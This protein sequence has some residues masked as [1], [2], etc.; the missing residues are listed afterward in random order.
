VVN[1]GAPEKHLMV[2]NPLV[3]FTFNWHQSLRRTYKTFSRK[4]KIEQTIW[5]S[6]NYTIL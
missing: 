5:I 1:S 2:M 3:T 4:L 6:L